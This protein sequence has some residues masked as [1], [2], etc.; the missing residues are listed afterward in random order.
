[1]ISTP[2]AYVIFL[3]RSA[4]YLKEGVSTFDLYAVVMGQFKGQFN[5]LMGVDNSINF[6]KY[7]N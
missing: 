7:Q 3:S 4:F 2:E 1:M 5:D 6:N